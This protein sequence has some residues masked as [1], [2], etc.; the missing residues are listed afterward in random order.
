MIY[1]SQQD[2]WFWFRC[3]FVDFSPYYWFV[4]TSFNTVLYMLKFTR[5][6]ETIINAV[7][8]SFPFGYRPVTVGLTS[9]VCSS[10]IGTGTN[11]KRAAPHRKWL[12]LVISSGL[13]VSAMA[14]D[15]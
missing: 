14:A 11:E 3:V 6:L 8:R 15:F 1:S 2:S 12:I 9:A 7:A 5:K 4:S 10:V 13:P